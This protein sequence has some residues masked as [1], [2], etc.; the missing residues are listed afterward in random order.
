[1]APSARATRSRCA[2]DFFGADRPVLATDFPHEIGAVFER[3]VSC[4]TTKRPG[5]GDAGR[6][7]SVNAEALFSWRDP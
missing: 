3:A 7:L 6:V 5:P 2:A 4:I 1:M